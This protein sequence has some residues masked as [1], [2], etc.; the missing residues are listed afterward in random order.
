MPE[1]TLDA[2]LAKDSA[3]PRK[4]IG[5]HVRFLKDAVKDRLADRK[6]DM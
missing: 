1:S 6:R 2:L 3:F 5:K 4:H